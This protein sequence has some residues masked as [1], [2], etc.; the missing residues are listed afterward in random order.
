MPDFRIKAEN[1]VVYIFD[2]EAD[3]IEEAL[4]MI[5]SGEAEDLVEHDSGGMSPVEYAIEGQMGWNSVADLES[6]SEPLSHA[7]GQCSGCGWKFVQYLGARQVADDTVTCSNCGNTVTF[8]AAELE[9]THDQVFCRGC[10]NEYRHPTDSDG[11][12]C[13][14]RCER[15]GVSL[16]LPM[17]EVAHDV[18]KA[19]AMDTLFGL[20]NRVVMVG[21]QPRH[22][23]VVRRMWIELCQHRGTQP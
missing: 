11:S 3:T 20:G 21:D 15:C 17:P 16:Y 19:E 13:P 6:E 14:D 12:P 8:P 1:V 22:A 10:G 2:V 9:P 18:T 5:E 4:D 23:D 7:E